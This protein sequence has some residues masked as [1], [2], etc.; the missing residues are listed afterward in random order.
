MQPL[1]AHTLLFTDV[2]D[3]TAIAARLGDAGSAAL[4]LAHDRA[5]RDLLRRHGGREIDR[6]DGF[7]LLFARARDAAAFALAY[8]EVLA[9]LGLHARAALHHAAVALRANV[10]D[11]VEQGA[12]PIE[13]DGLA[14][15]F[16]A[17]L[18]ALA[19]GGQTLVSAEAAAALQPLPAGWLLVEHGC[20]RLKGIAEPVPVWQLGVAASRFEPPTDVE[21][22]YAVVQRDGE[23]TPRREVRH[24]LVPER[25]GFV[26]RDAEL[27]DIAAAFDGGARLLTLAGTGGVGKT[28]LARRY[29]R[30]WLGDWPGGVAFCDLSEARSIDG[31]VFAVSS[32]LAVPLA[33]DDAATQLGHVMAA[34]GRCLL[35]LDNAEQV[36]GPLAGVLSGWLDRAGE[37]GFLVTSRE[38]LHLA[39]EQVVPIEPLPLADDAWALFEL[40]ARAQAPWLVL[41]G[42]QRAAVAEV[43]RL[44]D[45]L[46]LAIELAAAR[47]RMLSP[48][49][50]V[51][52]LSDR[53]RLLAG[54]GGP[55][56]R[57]SRQATLK[58]AIDWS[59]DLLSPWEQAALA[60]CSVFEGSFTLE[61]AEEVLDLSRWNEVPPTLDVL[62]ALVDKSLL[63]TWQPGGPSREDL[64][65]PSFGH[66]ISVQDYAGARLAAAPGQPAVAQ[67]RH[68]HHYARAGSDE[69]IDALSGHGGTVRRQR[70]A[71]EI[72]NLLAACRRAIARGDANVAT[73]CCRAAW[74]VLGYR[75]PFAL[76]ERLST[77][78][79]AMSQL[80]DAHRARML[81]VRSE[82]AV[83]GG[84]AVDV[85]ADL[86]AAVALLKRL[87][88]ARQE[89]RAWGLW[90]QRH[91]SLSR[92]DDAASAC[93]HA[94]E[95][96]R[97]HGLRAD[98]AV[99]LVQVGSLCGERGLFEASREHLESAL[100]L[101]REFGNRSVEAR[102]VGNLG[103]LS[104]HFG[105]PDEALRRFEE[106]AALHREVGNLALAALALNNIASVHLPQGR[107]DEASAWLEQALRLARDVGSRRVEA[108]V[109]NNLGYVHARRRSLDSA[110]GCFAAAAMLYREIGRRAGVGLAMMN[111]GSALRDLGRAD[112][113]RGRLAE[114]LE[115]ARELDDHDLE[116][117]TLGAL[118]TLERL[119][120]HLQAARTHAVA[121]ETAL[122][123]WG[124][125]LDIGILLCERGWIELESGAT[126]A[127]R[128]LL[129]EAESI[130]HDDGHA[131]GSELVECVT[132]L[133][134]RLDG[135]HA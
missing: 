72:D 19:S 28:R 92:Y 8:H 48:A 86:A 122:R 135:A 65:E 7:L 132:A 21:K 58:A 66:Y 76:G 84:L 111:L 110:C 30:L 124:D 23:W 35:I 44:L 3:S 24:N 114:A 119:V 115:I 61:A 26:G 53:F 123:R 129:R 18:L 104:D 90:G 68:G 69:A 71:L 87:G 64:P 91:H 102:V 101:L 63:R 9:G 37:A 120:G 43:V 113:A 73:A 36:V 17:R 108:L 95:L 40:R 125:R 31:I 34:R 4:W 39:G 128:S 50:I 82:A 83:A 98:E 16:A 13:I 14:K 47:V 38:R 52:R 85:D 54:S 60:Q 51:Q 59:W 88:D 56:A 118:A 79:L 41:D 100:P 116:G 10:P 22:A 75:G 133:R 106:S 45:G 1:L 33:R 130:A 49:Q 29:G 6:S 32:A 99:T 15:P 96:Q 11:D 55:A 80:D 107:L 105:A 46:P 78:V 103:S 20:Y 109:Q 70:L 94:L 121:A 112:E 127:A 12:K 62:Q 77:D 67:G 25:D 134:R 97:A 89:A 42:T 131:P 27:R 81:L 93:A 5:A 74:E 117:M 2:V 57:G 126:D